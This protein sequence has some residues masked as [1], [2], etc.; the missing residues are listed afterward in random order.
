MFPG[1]YI[2]DKF[3][4]SYAIVS[5]IG[6][7]IAVP[8]TFY[9][10]RKRCKATADVILMF[11]IAAIGVFLGMHIL[12]GITNIQ[13]FGL[14]F[15]V[16]DF[17]QFIQVAGLIFGGSVFYGGLLGGL[18]A[19][20]IYIK[21]AKMD[22]AL[23]SD[24]AAPAIAIFHGFGRVGCFL[25]GCCYGVESEHG[26]VFT[27]ALIESANG[28][29]RVPVQLYEAAFEFLLFF[30][31]WYFLAKG[32]FRGRLL[33]I[34]L[35]VY[36]VG[37]FILEFWRGDEYRGFLFGLSTSQIISIILFITAACVFIFS[38]RKNGEGPAEELPADGP[39]I[40]QTT[41]KESTQ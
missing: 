11:L 10:Y 32:K 16:K 21:K 2:A 37:R 7:F 8:F 28:V 34:Y 9:Y 35:T 40:I 4:N 36:P 39:E 14:L 31:L 23:T 5:L 1:F 26:I 6:A 24:C 12:Y 20:W 41:E 19:G 18:A 17:W 22:P 27:D 3:I 15:K 33:C 38:P 30:V 29:P 25:G 13:Y